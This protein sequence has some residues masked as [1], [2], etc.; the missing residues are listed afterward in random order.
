MVQDRGHPSY[1]GFLSPDSVTIAEALRPAGYRSMVAGK[2]H[3]AGIWPRRPGLE[4]SVGNPRKPLP[5]DRGFDRFYGCPG[6]GSY[7]FTS[8]L[9]EDDR[10]IEPGEGFYS[11]DAYTDAACRFIRDCAGD[12][13]SGGS[14]QGREPFFLHL[15]YQAPHW[16]LH[17]WPEDIERYRGKFSDGWDALRTA[18]HERLKASGVLDP[19]WPISARDEQAPPWSDVAEKDWEDARMA[20]YAAQVDR[21][22]QGIGRV[23]ETLRATGQLDNTLIMFLSDNGG[24]AE[25]LAENGRKENELPFTLDGRPV[26]VGNIPGLTPGGPETF[27]SYDLPWANVSNT[28]FRRFKHWVHEGGISTPLICHWPEGLAEPGRLTHSPW[29]VADVMPTLLELAGCEYPEERDGRPTKPLDGL[30][31]GGILAGRAEERPEP[32]FWEHEGNRAVRSGQWKLVSEYAKGGWELYDLAADRA[33][34]NDL[35]E[36]NAAKVAELSAAY[37]DF[38]AR[39]GVLPWE[40]LEKQ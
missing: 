7:F 15:T 12:G 21:M 28:P 25:F 9:M 36:S 4:W 13:S 18:R 1:R 35:A 26:R 16:P 8:P 29:H 24:C 19:R 37:D 32:I 5:I 39:C 23:I 11:T 2:W 14:P 22:D 10:F 33:E 34:T 40:L 30:S 38:A 20:V 27:M 17:A 3:V 6:G 31:F